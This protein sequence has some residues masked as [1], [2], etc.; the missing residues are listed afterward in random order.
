MIFKIFPFSVNIFFSFPGSPCFVE[1]KVLFFVGKRMFII[2]CNFKDIYQHKSY[3]HSRLINIKCSRIL[4][5]E[6]HIKYRIK[7]VVKNKPNKNGYYWSWMF[8]KHKKNTFHNKKK[9]NNCL[10]TYTYIYM[11]VYFYWIEFC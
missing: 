10:Q 6:I 1:W 7:F 3:I 8:E 5:L 11:C 4:K 9:C 2:E